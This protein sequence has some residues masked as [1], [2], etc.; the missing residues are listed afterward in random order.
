[1]NRRT[2][3]KIA[4]LYGIGVLAARRSLAELHAV[5]P[6]DEAGSPG[7]STSTENDR[8]NLWDH[9]FL[10]TAYYPE[11]W[12]PAEWEID[13]REM[14]ELGINTVR[15]GEF[16]WAIFEPAPGKFEFS[17][18]DRAI[19]MANRHGIDVIL[20]TP[21]ASVPPWL[22]QLH[23]DVLSGNDAGPFTYGGRKG[24]CTSSENYL[25]AC[26]RIVT[27]LA[28]HYGHY[29]G[30][31]GWQLDNEPG[32]PV[33]SYDPVSQ[34][35]FQAWL[36]KR[37]GTLATLNRTWNGAFWSNEYSD[38]SQIPIPKNSGEGGWQPAI[39]MDYRR[40]FSD[41]FLNH[42]RR[43]AAILRERKGNQFISTNWPGTTG[44][45]DVFA[46][47]EFLDATAWDN[48]CSAPG[49]SEFQRQYVAG[50]NHDVSRCAGPNQRFFCAEQIAYVPPNALAQGL[51]LQ[52]YIDLA[53]GSHGQLYFE[54]RRPL[55]GGE[56]YRPSFIKGFDGSVNPAKPVFEQIAKEF[57][58]LGPRLA[59][60]TTRSDV[61]LLYDFTNE[62]GQGY[63]L[64][65]NSNSHYDSEAY[66][67]Y[68]GF[69]VLQRNIDIV[70]LSAD[71]SSYKLAVAPNLRL[72][73]DATVQRLQSFVAAGGVLVLNF[74]AGTQN[75][76]G[77]M[78]RVIPPG[79]FAEMAG[80]I[81]ESK[82]DLIEYSGLAEWLAKKPE[83]ELGISF[84]GSNT[85]FRP[86]TILESL[87]LHGAEPVAN[88][89]GG[90]MA[91]K[92]AITRH[93]YKQGWV[94]YVGTDSA[95]EGFH[96]AVARLAGAAGG[97]SSLIDAPY[98]V[99][100]TSREDA[101]TNF[102]FLLN[103]TETIHNE[104]QLPHPMD[105]LI[106][107]RASV[108]KISLGP[109]EVAVLA[110]PKMPSSTRGR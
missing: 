100:V 28:E 41:S 16:A 9:Y 77:S 42:L 108:A 51:R 48:Y 6:M 105:D 70:P 98:G 14:Q 29:P 49:L 30:V 32:H 37:Y 19:A 78:R 26:A 110:S 60:A 74:R 13:F 57:K 22:Y 10:G 58:R 46:A 44:P 40:F 102:Y 83:N 95:E 94:F 88:F 18:M 21:T 59:G 104:I 31:I 7:Q 92:P 47:A 56:Q 64:A 91:G 93:R 90:R 12:E 62:W 8:R 39:S 55:A 107:G 3:G 101:D 72:V 109:L 65:G 103:L 2:F 53:H 75:M 84:S 38:W 35:A 23:P 61:V 86:R 85:V 87:V 96:E 67:Y 63:G 33:Q 17:W 66:R 54:W 11:W 25:D 27:A 52:A 68:N 80:V 89:R 82:L 5:A 1:M 99:E 69:K 81:A 73:D 15:M 50:F 34:R 43:Q 97:L 36:K 24:Y 106:A 76:D 20:C 79:V 45:V 71:L 4:G